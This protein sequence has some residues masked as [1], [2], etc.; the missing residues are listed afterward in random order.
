MIAI[1]AAALA[2][3]LVM[4]HHGDDA[5][6]AA[7]EGKAGA[8]GAALQGI[9]RRGWYAALEPVAHDAPRGA[10][11][12]DMSSRSH[13]LPGPGPTGSRPHR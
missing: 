7:L 6:Y 5:M 2:A 11:A 9:G 10:K 12:N 3:T 8:V 13:G 4:N 1:P